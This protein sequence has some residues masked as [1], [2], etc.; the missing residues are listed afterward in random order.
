MDSEVS[1][2]VVVTLWSMDG[3]QLQSRIKRNIFG[4]ALL[5]M[6]VTNYPSGNYVLSFQIGNQITAKQL[7]IQK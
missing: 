2:D 7:I 3:Q 6:D 1:N 5:E 4:K